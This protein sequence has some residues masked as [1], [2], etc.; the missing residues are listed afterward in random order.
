M[1]LEVSFQKIQEANVQPQQATSESI[2]KED[3]IFPEISESD[4]TNN[5]T[6]SS[7]NGDTI[8][9]SDDWFSD[10]DAKFE[11]EKQALKDEFLPQILN[12]DNSLN[13]EKVIELFQSGKLN[14]SDLAKILDIQLTLSNTANSELKDG[15]KIVLSDLEWQG[16]N[17][18]VKIETPDGQIYEY[19]NKSE[20]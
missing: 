9:D 5:T 19:S 13:P 1:S 3:L 16:G 4:S 20:E 2:H 17:Q 8:D 14:I 7:L 15:T 11:A 10:F 6:A 18:Y 12:E